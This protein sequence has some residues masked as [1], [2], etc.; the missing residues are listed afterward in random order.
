[1]HALLLQLGLAVREVG[2]KFL[3]SIK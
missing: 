2:P 1:M 3:Q